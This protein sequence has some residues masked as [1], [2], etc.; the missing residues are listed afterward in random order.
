VRTAVQ[1][2]KTH[3]D[4]LTWGLVRVKGYRKKKWPELHL[5]G[6]M[7]TAWISTSRQH[8]TA[9]IRRVNIQAAQPCHITCDADILREEVTVCRNSTL[10]SSEEG[11]VDSDK[12]ARFLWA[13]VGGII[14]AGIVRAFV[15]IGQGLAQAVLEGMVLIVVSL[16][17]Y[18][19]LARR[20]SND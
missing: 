4:D 2:I 15:P 3:E 11:G 19:F 16:V 20:S 9:I 18:R 8:K 10:M 6:R 13:G 14:C 7:T 12:T 1:R 17:I 5:Y